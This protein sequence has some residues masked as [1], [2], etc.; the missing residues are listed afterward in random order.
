MAT[1]VVS[2]CAPPPAKN[3]AGIL[4]EAM[5]LPAKNDKLSLQVFLLILSPFSLLVLLHYFLVSPLMHKVEDT[6]ETSSLDPKHLTA[7]IA[8]EIPFFLTFC[9]ISMFGMSIIVQSS[10]LTYTGKSTNL[11]ELVLRIVSNWKKPGITSIYILFLTIAYILLS[12]VSLRLASLIGNGVASNVCNWVIGVLASS[13]YLYLDCV[14]ILGFVISILEDDCYGEKAIGKARRL[15]RGRGLQ[16]FSLMLILALLSVPIYVLFY[17]TTMDDDDELGPVA[18]FAFTFI[19]T[20]LFS[21][22][23]FFTF[24]VLTVFHLECKQSHGENLETEFG[25]GYL[26]VPTVNHAHT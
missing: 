7:L 11:K 13:S 25:P 15:I 21:L 23:N 4:R 24:M 9:V 10:A 2:P 1:E 22:T 12:L 6:Y 5:K 17:V 8:I 19:A 18:R 16:G 20:V 3:T 26:L 14:W